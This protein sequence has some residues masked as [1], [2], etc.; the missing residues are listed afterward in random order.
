[1]KNSN[2][3]NNANLI[4]NNLG[5]YLYELMGTDYSGVY[6]T[7]VEVKKIAESLQIDI[8]LTDG[9]K[10]LGEILKTA[11]EQNI[12]SKALEEIKIL[13][14]TRLAIYDELSSKFKGATDPIE[15]WQIKAKRAIRKI[16]SAIKEVQNESVSN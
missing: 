11:K 6:I 15:E 14:E 2:M 5:F 10:I 13:F 16:E 9:H 12:L 7:N 8:K 1:M 4:S 3:N